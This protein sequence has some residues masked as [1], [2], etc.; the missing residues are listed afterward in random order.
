MNFVSSHKNMLPFA[1]L[2]QELQLDYLAT[3]NICSKQQEYVKNILITLLITLWR[4]VWRSV[5]IT[6]K[7]NPTRMRERIAEHKA[8]VQTTFDKGASGYSEKGC[9]YFIHFGKR[10][11]EHA[12]PQAGDAILDVAC[13]KGA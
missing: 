2:S 10:L 12:A 8:W 6:R 5:G 1:T 4:S 3:K 13:G 7:A 11:V 9:G